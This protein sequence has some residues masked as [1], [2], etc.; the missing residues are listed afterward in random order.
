MLAF[1]K[2]HQHVILVV[3]VLA[4][5]V[6]LR[7]YNL[8]GM[9]PGLHADEAA[10]GLD[11]FRILEHGDL[12]PFYSGNGG[13]EALFFYLQAA[14]IYLFGNTIEALRYAPALIGSLAVL[15]M[16]AWG[17]S[18]FGKWVGVTA[19]Y[20]M[21]TTPWAINFS[22][23]GFR[24]CMVALFVPLTLFLMTRAIQTKKATWS[25]AAGVSLGL[26]FYTYI[27]WRLFPVALAAI[28]VYWLWRKRKGVF[29]WSRVLAIGF[30][31]MVVTLIPM[32]IYAAKYPADLFARSGGVSIFNPELNHGDLIT[33]FATV[34]GQ[35]ALM[36]NVHGDNNYRHNLG[37]AP[38]F[39]IFIG[40]MFLL[41]LMLALIRVKQWKMFAL[42][43]TFGAMLLPELLT[44]EGIPHALRA[45]GALPAAVMFAALGIQYMLTVWRGV[46]PLNPAARTLGVGALV[47][48]L[49]LSGY[50]G[51]VQYHVAMP[52]APETYEAF[53]ESEVAMADYLNANK[54]NVK[55]YVYV[56][57][58][59][60]MVVEYITH[61]HS[62]Y[63]RVDK[64]ADIEKVTE[65][66]EKRFLVKT[67]N[68]SEALKVLERKYP[69]GVVESHVSNFS[70]K[71]LF[72]TYAVAK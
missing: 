60:G 53:N 68:K 69:D 41:G 39:N 3:A 45:I 55:N 46:F 52:N 62:T 37:G 43:A 50:Q 66:G 10:N 72:I 13:R 67:G 8:G 36:F 34:A 1:V 64:A 26:G 19:A 33:T 14:S 24:A 11:E 30:V 21:A 18:W 44:A 42:L 6:F 48:L 54:S 35:T 49:G 4:L 56:D 7:F 59:N 23:D 51:Y 20:I 17:R 57:G 71:E 70:G 61:N 58:Y 9:P 5:A 12:R 22:R 25:I 40:I 32:I 28:A 65:D 16:Y 2:R 27:A 31:S 38:E 15:A 63:T 29:E 47:V